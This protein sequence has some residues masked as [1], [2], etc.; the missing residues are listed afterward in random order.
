MSERL[1]VLENLDE[2]RSAL[3][4]VGSAVLIAPPGTGK[5]TGVPPELLGQDWLGSRRI[6]VL[7]PRRVAAR[8][9]ATRMAATSGEK[10]GETFGFSV[11]GSSKRSSRTKVEVVTEGLFLRRLQNDPSLDGVGA[12][13][14]DE[15]H[16]RSL[17]SDLTLALLLDSLA[18]L[19]PDLRIL[20]MSATLDAEPVA[21]LLGCPVI[22]AESPMFPV[23]T[24]YR[25]GSIHVPLHER[26]REVVVESLQNDQG[27]ILVFLPG[28][29]E[30]GR[31]RRALA[32][33]GVGD[34]GGVRRVSVVELHGSL[35]VGEQQLALSGVSGGPRRVVLS[36]SLA[37]TSI[38]VE[39]VR[40]VIDAGRRRTLSIDSHNGLPALVTGPV[41]I[42]GADQRRGRAGRTA[43][44]VAYR[45]WSESENRHRPP[46][47]APEIIRADLTALALQLKSWGVT[48]PAEMAWLDPPPADALERA[49][50]LLR[51]LGAVDTAGGLTRKGRRLSDIGFH[52]RLGAVIF[53]GVERSLGGLAAEVATVLEAAGGGEPDMVDRVRSLRSAQR[54]GSLSG[55]QKQA[56][57][58]WRSA[59]S[60]S[61]TADSLQRP[62]RDGDDNPDTLVA[63]VA[64]LMLA[65]FPDRVARRRDGQRFD[66]R[67]R[68][69]TV[70]HLHSGGEVLLGDGHP[71]A[72]SR[73]IVAVDLDAGSN[74][75]HLGCELPDEVV[76]ATLAEEFTTEESVRW[77]P[78]ESSIESTTRTRYGQIGFDPRPLRTPP[79]E[80]LRSA[81]LVALVSNGPGVFGR[82]DEAAK[83]R[84][85]V[86]LVR[87]NS[88]PERWPDFSDDNLTVCLPE[89]L[90][91]RIDRVRSAEDLDRIDVRA[92]LWDQLDWHQRTELDR[93]TPPEW[94][95]AG[96]RRVGLRYGEVDGDPATVLASVRLRD[97]FGTDAHPT[98]V[99]GRVR[100]VV[101]LLSPAGRPVQRTTDLPGFWRGSYGAVRSELRGRY[102]KHPWPDQPWQMLPGKR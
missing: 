68:P 4:T 89:W 58:Q 28:R 6:L 63:D 23:E 82:L 37:E 97:A 61:T 14:L 75:L 53:E 79:P 18:A 31:T 52:P 22:R 65:A 90:G 49:G 86:A 70:F 64:A 41:S 7:E 33:H 71:L 27:D 57:R 34:R 80:K 21:K 26:V 77:N 88:D 9:A 94:T 100:V 69:R 81:L 78:R 51:L 101:E 59:V 50:E 83:L 10:V 44:G 45:L 67:G 91:N 48:D 38:T 40:V 42:A 43:P 55:E 66:D 29:G 35:S 93:L 54:S 46:A 92:A 95:L 12:V 102:P 1:P 30:I 17:D 3:A 8:M 36:T 5:T 56:L 2:I 25:P 60:G 85:R 62:H 98:V 99:D 87:A 47:D 16:E 15:F 13:L 20:V 32:D 24:R 11:R 74:A 76:R 84:A 72:K 19:R 96:G 73:W 39:G